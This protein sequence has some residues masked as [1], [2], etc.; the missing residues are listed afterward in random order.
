MTHNDRLQAGDSVG[1]YAVLGVIAAGGCGAVYR[2]EHRMLKRKVAVKV[3][4]LEL[5]GSS[6]MI[7]RFVREARAVNLIHHPHIVDIFDFG[8]M[9]D[10]RPFYVMELLEGTSLSQH[11][12]RHGRLSPQDALQ[13]LEPVCQALQ[14]AHDAGVVH[15][16]LKGGNISV[17]SGPQGLKVKLL[18]FGIAKLLH[19][20]P[21]EPGLTTHAHRLGTPSTMAPEQFRGD[22][23]DPRTDVYALG[24]ILYQLLTGQLPFQATTSEEM[25]RSHL[26]APAPPPSR[27]APISPAMDA[28]VL[29]CLEKRPERRFPSAT[30]FLEALREA[31]AGN[32]A[33]QAGR[34]QVGFSAVGFYVEC[35]TVDGA[36]ELDDAFMDDLGMTLDTAAE[37]MQRAGL[38]L[39]LQTGNALLGVFL[40]SDEAAQQGP[41]RQAVVGA[42]R[43]LAAGL[44]ARPSAHRG[45]HVNLC[46]HFD[47][48]LTRMG[49]EGPEVVGGAISNVAAWAPQEALD[50]LRV[51]AASA[52][53]LGLS[54]P[55]GRF[56][57]LDLAS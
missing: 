26:H 31:V 30:T 43:R 2:A 56:P 18:D 12:E 9:P 3:M 42:A 1:E 54:E 20:E 11:I 5:A 17:G 40:L 57:R 28:I 7:Q 22:P 35:R 19:P 33:A 15:R 8:M 16:D 14:A 23:V 29:R 34:A 44:A 13:I 21:D 51:T 55:E 10:G 48:A 32:A 39:A 45:L 36:D 52:K 24:V 50:G 47:G 37:A 49:A 4:H 46:L 27:V 53:L 6:E 41:Q 38:V 25:E